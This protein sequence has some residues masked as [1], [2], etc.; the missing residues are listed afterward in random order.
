MHP[1]LEGLKPASFFYWFDKI[2]AIPRGSGSEQGIRAYLVSYAEEH[3][4]EHETDTAGNL[5]MRVPATPGYENEPMLLLQAHMDMV[6]AKAP[7]STHD[8]TRDAIDFRIEGRYLYGKDTNLG[9][10][11]GKGMA[12]MLAVADGTEFSHPALELL[13]TVQEEVGLVGIRNF[14]MSRLRSKRMINTDCGYSHG[15]CISSVGKRT[16]S[17][18]ETMPISPTEGL[19]LLCL[20]VKGGRGGHSGLDA[21]RNRADAAGVLAELLCPAFQETPFHL[22]SFTLPSASIHSEGSAVIAVNPTLVPS[23]Q[24]RFKAAFLVMKEARYKRDDPGIVFTV[25]PVSGS[26]N[27]ADI[28]NTRRVLL[29]AD[30]MPSAALR[31][32]AEDLSFI[33]SSASLMQLSFSEGRFSANVSVRSAIDNE[34]DS[35]ARR[36]RETIALLGFTPVP[37][38]WYG[39]WPAKADSV[40]LRRIE[41][42]HETLF[43]R[44]I[45]KQHIHGGIEASMV[46]EGC[47][48]MDIIGISPTSKGSHTTD[49]HLYLDEVEDFWELMKA[50]L[51][52]KDTD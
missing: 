13:F 40:L 17:V 27:A 30:L 35:F 23:L 28:E 3:G 11:N 31:H 7:G 1:V 21:H 42:A 33:I 2:S 32:D 39:G 4:Y 26:A 37:G 49:E 38:N 25:E 46:M 45:E 44:P 9:T 52:M 50:T 16:Y 41:A 36:C 14:D 10:D 8:F 34:C 43:G 19:A 47:P 18:E 29:F 51:A 6:W 48:W 15:V 20:S 24:E 5:L 12:F 22:V